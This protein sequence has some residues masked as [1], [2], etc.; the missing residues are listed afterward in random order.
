MAARGENMSTESRRRSQAELEP[1]LDFSGVRIERRADGQIQARVEGLDATPVRVTRCFPW[2]EPGRFLSLRDD[3]DEEVALVESAG[4]LD[5]A[6]RKVLEEGLAEAGFVFE[7]SE[8]LEVEEE[9]EIRTWRVRTCQG[10][11]SF[12]T[13]RDEWPRE[14][15]GGG[16]LIRDVAADLYYI[17]RP[18]QL[19]AS[20]QRQLW[21]F[22]D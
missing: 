15:P 11:R 8:I 9:I 2:T 16:L 21:A 12:Q 13:P 20:S 17:P 5:P 18:E 3:D 10:A 7:V 1:D 6:S 22:V 14:V 4:E 19:D